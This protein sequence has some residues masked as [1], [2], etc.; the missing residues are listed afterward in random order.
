M[1][2]PKLMSWIVAAIA[3]AGAGALYSILFN[4]EFQSRS[5]IYGLCIG[6][7]IVYY[8]RGALTRSYRERIRSLPT[9]AYLITAEASLLVVVLVGTAFSGLLVWSVGSTRET[10]ASVATPTLISV[11]YS[12]AFAAAFVFMFRIRDLVGGE[13]LTSLVLGRYHRPISEERVFLFL[14]LVGSTSYAR[15]HG[16]LAAQELLKAVFADVAEPVRRYQGQVD[17]YIGD[18]M[19]ISWPIA[20][21]LENAQCVACAFAIFAK[22]EQ[23]RSQWITQFKRF[24]ELRAALHGGQIV[25]AEVGVDRHKIAYFGDVMNTTARLE[26]LC[27]QTGE[28]AV[29]SEI[30]LQ[31]LAAFP[32]QIT[33]KPLGEFDLRGRGAA[34]SV[35]ALAAGPHLQA[36]R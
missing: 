17:D 21:G 20:R 5:L 19:I 36:T 32:A 13:I 22:L 16:D 2:E 34:L 24:P 18:Q 33:A 29:I 9:L 14:D 8:E 4:G 28:L 26:Q 10:L 6:L 15:D 31:R 25:T 1:A 12:M 7:M 11:V 30:L 23:N 27:R 35:Y 3:S